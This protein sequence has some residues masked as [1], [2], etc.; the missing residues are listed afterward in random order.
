MTQLLADPSGAAEI[1]LVGTRMPCLRRWSRIARMSRPFPLGLRPAWCGDDQS[2]GNA[3]ADHDAR[4]RRASFRAG[5]P[6]AVRVLLVLL[7]PSSTRCPY[8]A[9]GQGKECYGQTDSIPGEPTPLT[10]SATVSTARSVVD[11]DCRAPIVSAA[12]YG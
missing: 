7:M 10:T 9:C 1:G 2:S 6:A 8:P 5:A 4:S 11:H 3:Q 12:Q